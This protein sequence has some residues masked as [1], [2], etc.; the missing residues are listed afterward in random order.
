FIFMTQYI[1]IAVAAGLLAFIATPA[2]LI[3]ARRNGFVAEPSSRKTHHIPIP[4]LGGVAIWAAFVISLIFFAE[5]AEFRELA[6][7][8]I[9]GTL[10]SVVGLVDD[11]RGMR[12]R[13]KLFWQVIAALILVVG[14]VRVRFLGLPWLDIP[15]TIFWVVGICNAINFM[16]NMDGLAAGVAAIA[17]GTFLAIAAI[18]GQV[19]VSSL[20]AAL[21]GA[22]LGFLVYNFHPALT[23]MGDAGSLLLGFMLA[24]LGIKLNFPHTSQE[25]V[26][27][28]PLV[29]LGLPIFDTTLVTLSRLRRRVSVAQGGAD[30]TSHRMARLGLSHRRVVVSLYFVGIALGVIAVIMSVSPPVYANTTLGVMALVAVFVIIVLEEA[31]RQPATSPFR[32]DLRLV[33]IGG[34][35]EMLPLL[36]GAMDVSQRVT[37]LITPGENEISALRLKECINILADYPQAVSSVLANIEPRGS[38]TEM[39]GL[40]DEAFRLRGRMAITVALE[41]AASPSEAAISA[42][43]KCDL[44]LIGGELR[45]NVLPTLQIGGIADLLRRSKRARVLAHP[46]P[47]RALKEIEA[48]AGKDLITHIITNNQIEKPW[49]EVANLKKSER[50]AEALARL[51]LRRTRVRGTPSPISGSIYE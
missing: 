24:V 13:T 50:V 26:W 10:V 25:S 16:D 9:G 1:L 49:L 48:N 3:F 4:L 43:G 17:A 41:S 22:C 34:G 5:G 21:L 29:V 12:P 38:L 19:L 31:Y 46:D 33:F 35:E 47:Q 7:I 36:K 30:H 42:I 27:M 6:A 14:N 51:W 28:V 8:I 23:F 44:I 39:V 40:W 20:A 11:H 15:L 45:E 18:N 32:S 2:T 37:M